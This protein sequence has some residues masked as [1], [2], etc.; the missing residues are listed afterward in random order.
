MKKYFLLLLLFVGGMNSGKAQYKRSKME[1][2]DFVSHVLKLRDE[3]KEFES[4]PIRKDNWLILSQELTDE[5]YKL[6]RR[7]FNNK[8]VSTTVNKIYWDTFRAFGYN[9]NRS[10][11]YM[12]FN[13][14][15]SVNNKSAEVFGIYIPADKI[16]NVKEAILRLV[17]IAKEDK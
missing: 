2:I 13:S 9:D 5:C 16:E 4:E 11:L 3:T 15:V 7:S 17:E 1:T 10:E 6:V 12:Y 8:L 14:N